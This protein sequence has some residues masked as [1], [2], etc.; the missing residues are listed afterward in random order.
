EDTEGAGAGPKPLRPA[1]RTRTEPL[2]GAVP[3]VSWEPPRS[4][5]L[6]LTSLFPY[7]TVNSSPQPE[8]PQALRADNAAFVPRLGH[9]QRCRISRVIAPR[10]RHS[11]QGSASSFRGWM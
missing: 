7:E 10:E 4:A 11:R 1:P 9:G 8:T 5:R 2:S 3:C 6:F